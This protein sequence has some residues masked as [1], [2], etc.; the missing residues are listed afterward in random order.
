MLSLLALLIIGKD[1]QQSTP[2]FHF[3]NCK[4]C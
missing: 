2:H 3:R 4:L 1:S